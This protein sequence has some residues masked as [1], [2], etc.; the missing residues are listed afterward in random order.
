MKSLVIYMPMSW[1]QISTKCFKSFVNLIS[2]ESI[3]ELRTKYDV[4]PKLLIHDIFPLDRNRNDAVELALSN[5][6]EADYIFFAD[7]DQV[8]PKRTIQRLLDKISDEFPV[9]TGI[10]FRKVA[11]YTCVAGK[12]SPLTNGLESK[13]QSLTEQGFVLP[14]GGQ[15]LFYKP[16]QDF[17]VTQPVD[18]SGMGCVLVKAEIFKKLKQPYFGYVNCYNNGGDYTIDHC[19]EEMIFWAA[20]KKAGIKVLCDPSIRAGHVA[21]RVIGAMENELCG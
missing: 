20:L 11:P 18:V 16:L 2:P 13:R 19:S 8:F 6:Y 21:E 7:G 10:Y 1:P 12:Y 15:C 17:T 4:E 14:D 9:V 5:K 3:D